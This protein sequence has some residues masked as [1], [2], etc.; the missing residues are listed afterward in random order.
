MKKLIVLCGFAAFSLAACE[1]YQGAGSD[2]GGPFIQKLPDG[3]LA[4][5]SPSQ[6]LKA[7]RIDPETGCYVYRYQGPVE[8]TYLPLR[9]E[10]GS[11]ICTRKQ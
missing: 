6:D 11:P 5:V 1:E 4:I 8:T 2:P 10:N 7:V 9:T 3:V